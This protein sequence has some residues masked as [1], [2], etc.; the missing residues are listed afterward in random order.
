MCSLC[1]GSGIRTDEIGREFG[2]PAKVID[3]PGHPRHGERGW[4]N[5]CNGI[6]TVKHWAAHIPFAV[7]N[8]KEFV[9]FLRACGGF[10]IC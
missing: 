3:Q 9:V 6:G 4:C 7:E 10:A 5:G 1:D 8:V 2:H